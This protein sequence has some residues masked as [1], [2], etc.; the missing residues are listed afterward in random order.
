[1]RA[2]I[3]IAFHAGV[4][5]V[6]FMSGTNGPWIRPLSLFLGTSLFFL[7][8]LG[9]LDAAMPVPSDDFAIRPDGSY[10]LFGWPMAESFFEPVSC[11]AVLVTALSADMQ[12]HGEVFELARF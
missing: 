3:D 10:L 2:P 8:R 11:C 9:V 6:F 7:H 12:K 5:I 4:A 1:M